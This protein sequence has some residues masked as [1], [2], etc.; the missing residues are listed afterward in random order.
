MTPQELAAKVEEL[1]A[2]VADKIA[3]LEETPTWGTEETREELVSALDELVVQVQGLSELLQE[4]VAEGE[5]G[6]AEE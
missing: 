2:F 1:R 3:E 6:G 5:E 4:H